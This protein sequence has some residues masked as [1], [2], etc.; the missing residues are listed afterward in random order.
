MPEI[1][2]AQMAQ[3]LATQLTRGENRRCSDW[4]RM[5]ICGLTMTAPVISEYSCVVVV[6][7]VDPYRR[8]SVLNFGTHFFHRPTSQLPDFQRFGPG[9]HGTPPTSHHT[10]PPTVA[11]GSET[12]W[13]DPESFWFW[14]EIE[15]V[16][17]VMPALLFFFG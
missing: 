3:A 11:L 7:V 6:V 1:A 15:N 17:P 5:T 4:K 12:T 9:T 16:G 8:H 10:P 2:H 14:P 13:S